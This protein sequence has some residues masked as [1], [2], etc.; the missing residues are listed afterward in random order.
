LK[1]K[2]YVTWIADARDHWNTQI[3][4]MTPTPTPY[5]PTVSYGLNA[6]VSY[7]GKNWRSLMI[8]NS[9]TPSEGSSWTET[10]EYSN[11]SSII[12]SAQS[13]L[14]LFNTALISYKTNPDKEEAFKDTLLTIQFYAT[15]KYALICE[16]VPVGDA[17]PSEDIRDLFYWWKKDLPDYTGFYTITQVI[18]PGDPEATPNP[19]PPYNTSEGTLTLSASRDAA[20]TEVAGYPADEIEYLE[21]LPRKINKATK[22]RMVYQNMAGPD[23]IIINTGTSPQDYV[24]INMHAIEVADEFGWS[25]AGLN[26]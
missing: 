22:N 17:L 2:D 23:A 4:T 12:A 13:D 8:N 10:Y 5:V 19:I 3:P 25:I 9:S 16:I 1:L 7:N 11:L 21:S 15:L 14:D 24:K 18:N 6:Y 26:T 20:Y